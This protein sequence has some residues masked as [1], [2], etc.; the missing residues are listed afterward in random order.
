MADCQSPHTLG[1]N[2][3]AGL[4]S[5]VVYS[6]ERFV[7]MLAQTYCFLV[8]YFPLSIDLS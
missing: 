8:T 3:T 1:V 7:L 6:Y 4:L 2:C 5:Y